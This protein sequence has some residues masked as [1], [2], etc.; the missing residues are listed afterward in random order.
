MYYYN[1]TL[2]YGFV[3]SFVIPQDLGNTCQKSDRAKARNIP[4][5]AVIF[6]VSTLF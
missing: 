1:Y 6:R 3:N 2:K 4:A 5:I